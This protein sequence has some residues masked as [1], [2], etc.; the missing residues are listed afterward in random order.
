MVRLLISVLAVFLLFAAI[1]L[2]IGVYR[3]IAGNRVEKDTLTISATGEVDATPDIARGSIS[4]TAE[5]DDPKDLQ[6]E[7]ATQIN[8]IVSY[9]KA[10]GV[11]DK[12]I[13]T[14][15]FNLY[16]KYNYQEGRQELDGYTITQSLTVKFRDLQAIGAIIAGTVDLGAN[17]ISSL[18]FEIEDPENLRQE[19]R[20]LAL[21]NAKDKA[22]ELA[23]VAGVDLGDVKSFSESDI[24]YPTPYPLPYAAERDSAVG[25]GGAAPNIQPGSTKVTAVVSV[26][27]ELD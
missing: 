2:G 14:E 20:K 12:D 10:Q 7:N 3:D 15:N 9:L 25:L 1:G 4:V 23:L 17:A 8:E 18:V 16:P 19:A 26:T 5:G 27:F 6:D 24:S 13:K 21:E 11:E 22:Q